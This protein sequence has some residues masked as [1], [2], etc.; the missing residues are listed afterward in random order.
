MDNQHK[1]I[2]GYRDLTQSEI[3]M[4]NDIKTKGV[5]LQDL[6]ARVEKFNTELSAEGTEGRQVT[7]NAES[8]RWSAI[9]KTHFQEGLMSL[10]RAV[11]KPG[12][13]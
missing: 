1:K 5:E 3:D 4:M 11:A 8:Y 6:I 10:T 12:F 7:L 13:F 2:K 9:A